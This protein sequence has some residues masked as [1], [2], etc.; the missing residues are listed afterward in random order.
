M[1]YSVF[2]TR[3][4]QYEVDALT[5]EY[6]QDAVLTASAFDG[7]GYGIPQ[8]IE[9]VTD[10]VTVDEVDERMVVQVEFS[11][12]GSRYAYAVP[13]NL[14]VRIGD[15]V[16]TPGSF[17]NRKGVAQVVD[18]GRGGY[19]GTLK[20][21]VGKVLTEDVDEDGFTQSDYDDVEAAE[22]PDRGFGVCPDCGIGYGSTN[23]R[24]CGGVMS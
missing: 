1:R 8:V 5:P 16:V 23:S 6:A 17:S 2:V 22:Y 19:T 21:L 12:A 18:V 24:P 4:T 3:T 10:K 9:S 7:P 15:Y 13:E 11:T 20:A 14:S